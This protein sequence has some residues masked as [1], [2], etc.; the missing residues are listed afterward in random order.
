MYEQEADRVAE[1]VT[2]LAEPQVQRKRACADG[3]CATCGN[4]EATREVVQTKRIQPG[5]NG[6]TAAPPIVNEVLRSSGQLLNAS[7]RKFMEAR[8]GHDFSHVRTHTDAQA[9]MSAREIGAQAYTV[10]SNIVFGAGQYSP[11]TDKGRRLLAH[12][13]THVIQQGRGGA[14]TIQRFHVPHAAHTTD[15][16]PLI[17]PTYNDL[18]NTLKAIIAAA[19]VKGPDNLVNMDLLVQKAGG[20]PASAQIDKKLGTKS[21]AKVASMLNF[22]YL[23][24]CRCG[25]I[26]MRHFIEL[27]YVSHYATGLGLPSADAN[28]AATRKGREHE[29]TSESESRFGPEDTPT[30][31]LGS[32]TGTR[33]AGF[34]TA[35]GLLNEIATT[36]HRCGPIDFAR[37]APASRNTIIHHYADLVPD[38]APKTPGDLIPAHQNQTALPDILNIPECGGKERSFP[39]ELDEDDPDRKTIANKAFDSGAAGLESDS[40]IRDFVKTQRTEI[41]KAL[42]AAEKVRLV[43]RLFKGW[44]ADEDLDAIQVIYKNSNEPE[45]AQIRGAIDPGDLSDLGQRTRLRLLFR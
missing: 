8:F 33:L 44:V 42:P 14:A 20:L 17:A 23:F 43:K 22:R 38:P 37:L 28:R 24:T 40:D 4:K 13:L 3:S 7:S 45:K 19:T 26:D 29:L 35:D 5:G 12:E 25:L 6:Q 30:N 39:F 11:E 16:V 32:F 18:L 1:Q 10:G 9:A 21:T 34:P 31:A 41:I 2:S 27:M 36:L 15:E